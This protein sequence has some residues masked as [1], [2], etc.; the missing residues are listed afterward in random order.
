M[1]KKILSLVF[2]ISM[3]FLCGFK[4][5]ERPYVIL[6]AGTISSTTLQRIERVFFVGQRIN[7]AIVSP[8]G[9]KYSGVRMQLSTQSDKTTNY[10]YSIISTE[11]LF[12]D[13]YSKSYQN[14]FVPR[15]AGRYILQFFYLNK[16][17]YPFAHVEF[18]VQ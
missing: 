1:I 8:D 15:K 2:I 16:K 17:N 12:I 18:M 11:D 14:Y 5:K 6:S 9:L 7:Y 3:I 10:G 13:K 4:F